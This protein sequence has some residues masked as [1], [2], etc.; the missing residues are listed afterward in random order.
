[1]LTPLGANVYRILELKNMTLT[2][3]SKETNL[4]KSHLSTCFNGKATLS[5]N[6]LNNIA[7]GLG[8]SLDFLE[9]F[10]LEKE[11]ILSRIRDENLL[12]KLLEIDCITE[13]SEY[14]LPYVQY[15]YKNI[16]KFCKSKNISLASLAR[17][18]NMPLTSFKHYAY[19]HFS[20]TPDFLK[21]VANALGLT[22]EELILGFNE[23]ESEKLLEQLLKVVP[24][25]HI[26]L[27]QLFT[28]NK[29]TCRQLAERTGL[30]Y[31][32]IRNYLFGS[33]K[34]D[35]KTI[36]AISK[37]LHIPVEKTLF[38]NIDLSRKIQVFRRLNCLTLQ[39]L[40]DKAQIS[41]RLLTDIISG[42][43]YPKVTT[44]KNIADA[45]NISIQ[46][47]IL[48]LSYEKEEMI[49]DNYNICN[50]LKKLLEMRN[51]TQ[52]QIAKET[53]L[54]TKTVY[55]IVNGHT[56]SIASFRLILEVIN[57]DADSIIF[58]TF[59]EAVS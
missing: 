31:Y 20:C 33:R 22:I 50:N 4:S 7:N 32:S 56:F 39:E 45:L 13:S 48:G 21:S 27:K 25:I 24:D 36:V 11:L 1:M 19:G 38:L 59:L 5:S 29:V 58:G 10:T 35:L 37:D 53:F 43:H 28:E 40:A 30:N 34:P 52:V 2:D 3:L 14:L 55:N 46:E 51:I 49:L 41:M 44:L 57:I 9:D 17:T 6:A 15:T 12:C 26:N 23:K 47:L 16:A 8:V 54:D 18:L 42:G